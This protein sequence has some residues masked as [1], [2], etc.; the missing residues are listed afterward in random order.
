M[1]ERFG[2]LGRNFWPTG[3]PKKLILTIVGAKSCL[4]ISATVILLSFKNEIRTI[5]Y[6]KTF[7]NFQH[8]KERVADNDF[9][10]DK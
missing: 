6:L 4:Q 5:C 2:I 3:H 10:K 9:D 8:L 1:A 7:G